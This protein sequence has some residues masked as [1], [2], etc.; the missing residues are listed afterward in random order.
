[1]LLGEPGLGLL[2]DL[3][4]GRI[5]FAEAVLGGVGEG[6]PVA[7]DQDDDDGKKLRVHAVIFSRPSTGFV[8]AAA[9][10]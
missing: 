8:F 9:V 1:M 2:L 4:S 7:N 10:S 6:L 3:D 5:L